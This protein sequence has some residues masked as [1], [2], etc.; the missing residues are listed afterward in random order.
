MA[1]GANRD[2][3][4]TLLISTRTRSP[5]NADGNGHDTWLVSMI[6]AVTTTWAVRLSYRDSRH[7]G[8]APMTPFVVTIT[9]DNDGDMAADRAWT[10]TMA[11]AQ[12]VS[13]WRTTTAGC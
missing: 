5:R 12:H 1:N 9:D 6:D 4:S 8:D 11:L 2:A 3:L 7:A 10:S 13:D